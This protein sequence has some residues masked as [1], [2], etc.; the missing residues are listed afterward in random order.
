MLVVGPDGDVAG[1]CRAVGGVLHP[2]KVLA[3][4]PATDGRPDARPGWL[5][6]VFVVLFVGL[7]MPADER[8][9]L[10]IEAR[11]RLPTGRPRLE[12]A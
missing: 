12:A 10:I 3:P 7:A 2:S 4:R 9:L 1:V 8:R 5:L 11:R 6:P